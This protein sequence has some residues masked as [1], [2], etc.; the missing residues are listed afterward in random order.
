[1]YEGREQVG[2]GDGG[3]KW[4][5][6]I[7]HAHFC[8]NYVKTFGRTF[9]LS[10]ECVCLSAWYVNLVYPVVVLRGGWVFVM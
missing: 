8:I 1:M 3:R 7:S 2:E 10:P 6:R 9:S 4:A 5:L